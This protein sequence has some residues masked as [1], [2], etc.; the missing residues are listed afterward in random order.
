MGSDKTAGPRLLELAPAGQ[1]ESRDGIHAT[2][3]QFFPPVVWLILAARARGDRESL[4]GMEIIYKTPIL[5]WRLV[6]LFLASLGCRLKLIR[7]LL[8]GTQGDWIICRGK[9]CVW[10]KVAWLAGFT[11]PTRQIFALSLFYVTDTRGGARSS[12]KHSKRISDDVGKRCA[13]SARDR[14]TN[15]GTEPN[16]RPVSISD[17]GRMEGRKKKERE[18]VIIRGRERG[19]RG[20]P[21]STFSFIPPRSYLPYRMQLPFLQRWDLFFADLVKQD[22]GR[23]RQNS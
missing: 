13:W 6:C 22:P 18:R 5:P 19:F 9:K 16:R 12:G 4:N 23:A 14:G 3:G 17:Q 15:R 1:R 7:L 11:Q 21:H 20:L 8:S 10:Y 2:Y